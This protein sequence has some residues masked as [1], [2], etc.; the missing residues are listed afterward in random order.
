MAI[1]FISDINKDLGADLAYP[2]VDRFLMNVLWWHFGTLVLLVFLNAVLKIAAF[3]PSPL[4]WRVVSI[5]EGIVTVI[6]ALVATLLPMLLKGK[7]SNH[8][9]WRVLM[10]SSAVKPNRKKFSGPTSSRISTL[11]P[12][13]VPMVSAPFN[14]NFMLPVPDASM[15]A[16]E[17]CS[18][19]LAAG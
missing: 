11:A 19:K 15:P 8:Y 17:I 2:K 9:V 6:I 1:D 16:V 4:S 7:F 10:T 18:D 12:S 13:R 3:Y 14:E 5:P